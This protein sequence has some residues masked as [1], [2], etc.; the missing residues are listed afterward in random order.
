[1]N[2]ELAQEDIVLASYGELPDERVHQLEQHLAEC[3]GCRADMEAVAALQKA[4]EAAPVAEPSPSLL[5]RTRLRLDEALDE[6]PH[7][8]FL[9]RR[10]QSFRR[11]VSSLG[12]A[13]VMAS[14]L[15]VFGFAGGVFGG[16]HVALRHLAAV[17]PGTVQ[18]AATTV[19][20]LARLSDAQVAGIS[21]ITVD[22]ESQ[23]IEVSFD[24]LVPETVF[25]TV[26]DPQI[27]KLLVLGTV[28]GANPT[29]HDTSVSLLARECHDR[30]ECAGGPVRD[31]LMAALRYDKDAAVRLKALFGL[32]PYITV[33][34]RVRD[35]VLEALLND[36]NAGIRSQAITLLA[37]VDADSSVRDV[38]Q[39]VATQDNDAS[40]RNISRQFLEQVSQMQI[41]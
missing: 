26:A 24:R 32:E 8:G 35:A 4:L 3:A 31:A 6:M 7:G 13:P 17:H 12:H 11:G 27:R 21:N 9:L 38:L 14:A 36:P 19:P 28:S 23:S 1:M 29:V 30:R 20:V 18:D 39:T 5:A 2:C 10:W 40:I 22:P 15:L 16:Y 25:G 34:T 37:P 41:Q 33:D